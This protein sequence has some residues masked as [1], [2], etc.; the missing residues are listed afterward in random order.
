[1]VETFVDREKYLGT[2]YT[3]ANWTYLGQTKG[4]GR[5]R[6]TFVYHGRKK[7]IY[8]YIMDRSFTREFRPDLKRLNKGRE[9]YKAMINGIPIWYPSK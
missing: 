3:A 1:M 2:C 9:E 4:Y 7:D 6:N 8:V 5:Q